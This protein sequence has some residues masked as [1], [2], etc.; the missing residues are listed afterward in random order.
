MLGIKES[1]RARGIHYKC[2]IN[3][4]VHPRLRP[5]IAVHAFFVACCRP[6]DLFIPTWT[7][8]RCVPKRIL[9]GGRVI[10]DERVI[11][12]LVLGLLRLGFAQSLEHNKGA[13]TVFEWQS[14]LSASVDH[15]LWRRFA[16]QKRTTP[17]AL[18]LVALEVSF[19]VPGIILFTAPD[20]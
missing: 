1:S 2:Q 17:S 3:A 15:F 8:S 19:S 14:T 7:W 9:Q 5:S 16:W 11:S 4:S 20:Q 12:Q 13:N 18:W 6:V 10:P